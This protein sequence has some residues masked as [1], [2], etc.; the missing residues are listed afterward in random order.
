MF[1]L[2]D[3][4]VFDSIDLREVQWSEFYEADDVHVPRRLYCLALASLSNLIVEIYEKLC[5]YTAINWNERFAFETMSRTILITH[6]ANIVKI[7]SLS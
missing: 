7:H 2:I 6:Y 5:K 3:R 4:P 1:A